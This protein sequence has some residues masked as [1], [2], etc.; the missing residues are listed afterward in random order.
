MHAVPA[1]IAVALALLPAIADAALLARLDG[2]AWYDD[3]LDLTWI[4]DANLAARVSLGIAGVRSDGAMSWDTAQTW[5]AALNE[6]GYLGQDDWRLPRA[7]DLDGMD[8]DLH[9]GDGCD[10][11]WLNSDCGY[12]PDPA[13]GEMV[14]LYY[15]TL[16]NSAYV[17]PDGSLNGCDPAPDFCLTNRGPFANL[18]AGR[19]WYGTTADVNPGLAWFLDFRFGLQHMGF[20]TDEYH[21]LVVRDG[22]LAVVPLPPAGGLLCG[23]FA[24]LPLAT[25][26]GSGSAAARRRRRTPKKINGQ[27]LRPEQAV[28]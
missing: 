19:Y 5:I 1:V 17:G 2:R 3:V 12:N 18:Q 14:S 26:S 25:L 10:F 11:G 28:P 9:G 24:M 15:G 13:A 22:D 20:R 27:Q 8:F 7:R 21:V 23:A 16:G 4:A 6:A